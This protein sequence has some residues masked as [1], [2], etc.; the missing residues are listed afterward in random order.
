MIDNNHENSQG[1]HYYQLI[2]HDLHYSFPFLL[3]LQFKQPVWQ[4]AATTRSAVQEYR[5]LQAYSVHIEEEFHFD[6]KHLYFMVYPEIAFFYF[7]ALSLKLLWPAPD[8]LNANI[9][10]KRQKDTET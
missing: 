3:Y 6:S 1:L 9:A 10:V 4:N 2:L 8:Q 7:V 5:Q